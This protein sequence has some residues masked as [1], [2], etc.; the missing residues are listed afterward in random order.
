M[1]IKQIAK[2][3]IK[4]ILRSLNYDM[5]RKAPVPQEK[6]FLRNDYNKIISIYDAL[7]D[8]LSKS[9]FFAQLE[10]SVTKNFGK[11]YE[12]LI[13]RN[14]IVNEN[15]ILSLLK[16]NLVMQSDKIILLGD[17][18]NDWHAEILLKSLGYLNIK[19]SKICNTN[20]SGFYEVDNIS[21]DELVNFP[22]AKIIMYTLDGFVQ[23]PILV[24]KGLKADNL[25]ILLQEISTEYFD[26]DIMIPG[27][28][29]VF[30]DGGVCDFK[31]SLDFI[32]WCKNNYDAIYGFEPDDVCFK[33]TQE[34]IIS[35]PEIDSSKIKMYKA[36]CWSKSTNLQFI[37]D[38]RGGSSINI[39]G[40]NSI[41]VIAI[42][43]VVP[44]DKR[45]TFIKLDV[46]GAEL[47][48]LKGAKETIK[49]CRPKL[50]ICI[51]HKP[52][53]ILELPSYILSLHS[54]Y[55]MYIR[56]YQHFIY[57]NVLLCV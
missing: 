53:D 46:E 52:E 31:T 20:Q 56:H 15:N 2:K 35:N 39:N 16:N 6:I 8:D 51:Y 28:H 14:D 25:Y 3:V 22:D 37:S 24:K 50:A 21:F 23:K 10:Y 40:G 17:G 29:E 36:G 26:S 1:S 41:K 38:G 32:K 19:V 47:E 33:K 49:R 7:N 45:V 43:T 55:K 13:K 42:D 11:V 18:K 44:K 48:S 30:V 27:E 4:K 57:E 12:L 34:R 9:L 5:L 54:D